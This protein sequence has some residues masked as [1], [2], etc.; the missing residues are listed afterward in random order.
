MTQI[1]RRQA[2]IRRI[3]NQLERD[4]AAQAEEQS[5][6]GPLPDLEAGALDMDARYHIG[7]TQNNP[8]QISLFLQKNQRDPVIKVN[9]TVHCW[10]STNH[11]PS[12]PKDFLPKLKQHLL[13]RLQLLLKIA[14]DAGV[15]N[16]HEQAQHVF[17]KGERMYSHKVIC[18]NYTTYDVRRAQDIINPRTSHCNVM[19]LC[20]RG[21]VSSSETP[22]TA[23]FLRADHP[24]L[25][26]RVLGIFHANVIYTGPG[27]VDYTPK[28]MDFLWV[29]WYDHQDGESPT[30]LDR[31][32]FPPINSQS[33]RGFGFVDPADVVRGSHIIPRFS[34]GRRHP[35]GTGFSKLA[36]DSDDWLEYNI[37]RYLSFS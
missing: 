18:L 21:A 17:F 13:A 8:E 15:S 23:A 20:E 25:Y 14:P 30:R 33:E 34:K 37:G 1:E 27:M 10:R 9:G 31:L 28:R 29:R 24:Y 22:E 32:S 7:K 4:R 6:V 5:S 35:D 12:P 19:L 36:H 3:R 11:R 26:A 16:S 2:R